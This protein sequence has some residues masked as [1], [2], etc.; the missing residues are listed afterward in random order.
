[1][2]NPE[3]EKF[4]APESH[5]QY[6]HHPWDQHQ[7]HHHQQVITQHPFNVQVSLLLPDS[8]SVPREVR[9]VLTYDTQFYHISNLPVEQFS[10]PVFVQ[11][12]INNGEV[13]ALSCD[14]RLDVDD[15]AAITPDGHLHL[16]LG[17]LTYHQVP[18]NGRLSRHILRKPKER[19]V[20]EM[21]LKDLSNQKKVTE[22]LQEV[23]LSFN[24]WLAWVPKDPG[25]CP[26]SVAKYF[27][28]LSYNVRE[29]HT[30]VKQ[31]VLGDTL[32]PLLTKQEEECT[33]KEGEKTKQTE[34][35]EDEVEPEEILEWIG[36]QALGVN[37]PSEA[38][39]VCEVTCPRPN[40]KVTNLCSAHCSG[41]FTP[42]TVSL[43]VNR[44]KKWLEQRSE[45]VV[46]WVCATVYGHPD[47]LVSWLGREH[48][49]GAEGDN[50][51]TL[52]LTRMEVQVFTVS[53]PVKP[54]RLYV[55]SNNNK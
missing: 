11:T 21:N 20:V 35:C 18:L 16:L 23:S 40:V 30:T 50:M 28:D 19:F 37:L 29:R 39:T 12:F 10:N 47:S 45:E 48:T 26:S 1:M 33:A 9:D 15:S 36:C 22:A 38:T 51:Y 42:A 46:P 34:G 55:K 4:P 27:H 31:K 43:M 25:V 53:G 52:L 49:F 6:S 14:T 3:T 5:I 32:M 41:F 17:K 2:L 44:L 8:P 7:Y 24:W 54:K 13:Y